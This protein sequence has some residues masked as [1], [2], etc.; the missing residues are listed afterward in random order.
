M[1]PNR[2]VPSKPRDVTRSTVTCAA[3]WNSP[4]GGRHHVFLFDGTWNDETGPNPA[5]FFWD[6]ERK[7]WVSRTDPARAYAPIITNVAKTMHALAADGP[8]QLTH[9]F[10]GVGNDDENDVINKITEGATAA[11]EKSIRSNAYL[12]F[13]QHYRRGDRISILGF[14]RGAAS[15]RLFARDLRKRGLQDSVMVESRRQRVR[16]SGDSRLEV[17]GLYTHKSRTLL[18]GDRLDLAFIGVWDTVATSLGVK[19]AE[20]EPDAA[21]GHV[22]HCVALDEERKLYAPSL[23]Q[24]SLRPNAKEVW[25]PGCHS[26]VGG[27]YFHDA[28]GRLTLDFM[29]R[30]WI[31]ALAARQAAPLAWRP[32]AVTRFT[33][34]EKLAWLRHSEGGLTAKLGLSA[35]PCGASAGGRPRVHPAVEKFV[36]EGG[37]FFAEEGGGFPPASRI[38]NSVYTP[39]AY[40]GA[41]GVE[42]YDRT[43]WPA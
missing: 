14:S 5:D 26:D 28:L 34:T 36:Q 22:V 31:A 19:P 2:T 8:G 17:W 43:D 15:A 1:P 33:S 7:L 10:R 29:W 35:R 40:P 37:L 9:Y 41:A 39:P 30:N 24:D 11:E 21:V 38:S 23:L 27:G 18:A 13:L 12:A 3:D 4:S 16:N 32:D 20:L 42:L 6:Q 25:F